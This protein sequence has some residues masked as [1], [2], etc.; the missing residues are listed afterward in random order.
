MITYQLVAPEHT[1]G[2]LNYSVTVVVSSEEGD[3]SSYLQVEP[4]TYFGR[5]VRSEVDLKKVKEDEN[6]VLRR[7][8]NREME[9]HVTRAYERQRVQRMSPIQFGLFAFAELLNLYI[10][11]FSSSRSSTLVQDWTRQAFKINEWDD[12]LL[13]E[14][15]VINGEREDSTLRKV[16]II[17]KD[18]LRRCLNVIEAKVEENNNIETG[19]V[20]SPGGTVSFPFTIKAPNL[21]RVHEIDVQFRVI[22]HDPYTDSATI[23]TLGKRIKVYPSEFAIPTGGM[24]GAVAGYGIKLGLIQSGSTHSHFSIIAL[25]ASVFLGLVVAL[26]TSKRPDTYKVITVEDFWGG[27][28]IGAIAGM[29]ADD[30]LGRLRLF[31]A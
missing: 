14:R 30:I 12:V 13:L 19:I 3:E 28:I 24:L 4:V 7:D 23:N 21:F 5:L 18:K 16:F 20:L 9:K 26:I 11:V 17:D 1:V 10:S 2:S 22:F 27:F 8:P 31:A 29:F 6:E 15:E 25:I